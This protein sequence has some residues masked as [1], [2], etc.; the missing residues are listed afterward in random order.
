MLFIETIKVEEFEGK[1]WFLFF[2]I[3]FLQM[4]IVRKK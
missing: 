1:I 4:V 2:L 3:C